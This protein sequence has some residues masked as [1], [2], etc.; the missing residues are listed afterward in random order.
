MNWISS[1]QKAIDYVENHI[2]EKIDFEEVA[3]EAC[4]SVFHFQRV[5]GIMSV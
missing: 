2:T 3:K 1:L 4:S 5:F